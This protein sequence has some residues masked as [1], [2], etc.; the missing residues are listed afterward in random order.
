MKRKHKEDLYEVYSSFE[1]DHE[2]NEF[3][4]FTAKRIIKLLEDN[5]LLVISDF[6]DYPVLNFKGFDAV[7]AFSIDWDKKIFGYSFL[8]SNKRKH[9]G[10]KKTEFLKDYIELVS[11]FLINSYKTIPAITEISYKDLI[12]YSNDIY[13]VELISINS[14]TEYY[15]NPAIEKILGY[16]RE[17]FRLKSDIM[18]VIIHEEDRDKFAIFNEVVGIERQR[19]NLD[20]F[21]F[22]IRLKHASGR[23]I[24]F[25]LRN[26]PQLDFSRKVIG[27]TSVLRDISDYKDLQN[28]QEEQQTRLQ[29]LII[30]APG[31]IFLKDTSRKYIVTS[32]FYASLWGLTSSSIIGKTDK[33][34]MSTTQAEKFEKLEN[35]LS[36]IA[37]SISNDEELW[38]N[39]L[40]KKIYI[41][42][43]RL[44][45]VSP[46]NTII[47][48]LGLGQDKTADRSLRSLNKFLS[49]VME[50]SIDGIIAC[51]ANGKIIFV[52]QAWKDFYGIPKDK[53]VIGKHLKDFTQEQVDLLSRRR[54]LVSGPITDE[55]MITRVDGTQ[56]PVMY[57]SFYVKSADTNE[58]YYVS[59]LKDL[60]QQQLLQRELKIQTEKANQA[61]KY[62]SEL[63]AYVTHEIKNPLNTLSG[64]VELLQS[65]DLT[66]T[67]KAKYLKAISDA[68]KRLNEVLCEILDF[69]KIESGFIAQENTSFDLINTI[70]SAFQ[71]GILTATRKGLSCYLNLGKNLPETVTG[72]PIKLKSI[73]LNLLGNATKFTP[74]GKII[75][76]VN[77]VNSEENRTVWLEFKVTDTG[78]GIPKEHLK[79][80]FEPFIQLDPSPRNEGIG[81]GLSIIKQL[82]S[83]SDGTIDLQSE[84]NKGTCFS[85]KLPFMIPK[86]EKEEN[87][88]DKCRTNANIIPAQYTILCVDDDLLNLALISEYLT[89]EGFQVVK[90]SDGMEA[91]NITNNQHIDLIIMDLFMPHKDGFSATREIKSNPYLKSIPVF[92]LTAAVIMRNKKKA[93]DAGFDEILSK[94]CPKDKLVNLICG[95]LSR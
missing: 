42:I 43:H 55:A 95:Y 41:D 58:K 7:F 2:I 86:S 39:S 72:D 25:H 80:I 6:K 63:L 79:D 33:D 3:S 23:I 56:I 5:R 13:I 27:T 84:L 60:S 81:L 22:E 1:M 24:W 4:A 21:E 70:Q 9:T 20:P 68:S 12:D 88:N 49:Q 75:L 54:Q 14:Q 15:I 57:T 66:D 94:P 48:I 46:S 38:I 10:I 61:N 89:S 51:S 45:L 62:K 64:F 28:F 83:L 47:G 78:I 93:L 11:N 69:A 71:L 34:I 92:A 8:L 59:F 19:G 26:Y 53:A 44:L 18:N 36:K 32:N 77:L 91:I 65:N 30:N 85:V 40:S 50:D 35:R 73:L 87:S 67:Q 76:D 17:F 74:S 37:P 31:I 29:T 52:N 90:A 82:V 16:D